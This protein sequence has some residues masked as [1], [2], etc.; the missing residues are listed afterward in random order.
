M[1]IHIQGGFKDRPMRGVVCPEC[2]SGG[3][4]KYPC[5]CWECHQKGDKVLMLPSVNKFTFVQN[6]AEAVK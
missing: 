1:E 3:A 4:S 2:G 5:W 6:W